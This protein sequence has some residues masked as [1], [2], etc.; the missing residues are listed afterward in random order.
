MPPAAGPG[1][2]PPSPAAAIPWRL[3][4]GKGARWR[5]KCCSSATRS[6]KLGRML[7]PDVLSNWDRLL[8]VFQ[9][10]PKPTA[11]RGCDC[12]SCITSERILALLDEDPRR[13]GATQDV[14]TYVFNALGTIGTV[15]ELT[16]LL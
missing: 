11:A 3:A 10:Y 12:T 13:L 4:A 2:A 8:G 15:E 5:P 6:V 7:P 9:R 1:P 14:R 16:Y